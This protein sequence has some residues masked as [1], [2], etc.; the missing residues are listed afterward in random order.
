M[1]EEVGREGWGKA[2]HGGLWKGEQGQ[3]KGTVSVVKA[4]CISVLI[5]RKGK[6]KRERVCV[7]V[8]ERDLKMLLGLP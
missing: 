5:S 8:R 6:Q 3:P 7:K 2:G 4:G 1:T